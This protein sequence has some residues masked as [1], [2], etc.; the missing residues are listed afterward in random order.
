MENQESE[1][2]A[3]QLAAIEEKKRKEAEAIR[4]EA[5]NDAIRKIENKYKNLI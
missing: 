1:L 2:I 3:A 5:I 4:Q